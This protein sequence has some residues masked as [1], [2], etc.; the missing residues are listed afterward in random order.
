[1]AR[2]LSIRQM[3]PSPPLNL[4]R[5]YGCLR[6]GAAQVLAPV[7]GSVPVKIGQFLGIF[8]PFFLGFPARLAPT[9]RL[10]FGYSGGC[11]GHFGND[12]KMDAE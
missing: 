4:W 6:V 8:S 1:M 7:L 10:E 11:I 9:F 12:R 3:E 2:D 5:R